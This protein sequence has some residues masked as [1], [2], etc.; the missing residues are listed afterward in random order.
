MSKSHHHLARSAAVPRHRCLVPASGF[1][2][3]ATVPGRKAKQPWYFKLRDGA[4]FG[5]AGLWTSGEDGEGS[6]VLLTT[7][8]NGLVAPVHDRMPVI[9]DP[10]DEALWLDPADLAR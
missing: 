9:L 3:W 5:F 8:P 7:A 4:P 2:E 10:E 1:Y 6:F